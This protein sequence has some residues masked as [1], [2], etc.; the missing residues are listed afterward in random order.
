MSLLKN[1][2]A[3]E[4]LP[5]KYIIIAL[6]AAL[7]V[8]IA[9]QFTGVLKGG[10]MNTANKIN[11]STTM[12]TTCALDTED[13]VASDWSIT[14]NSTTNLINVASVKVTD[15]CDLDWVQVELKHNN[16]YLGSAYLTESSTKDVWTSN[17]NLDFTDSN[18]VTETYNIVADDRV[19]IWAKDKASTPNYA[20]A[21]TINCT[22]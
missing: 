19:V 3:V 6:V 11:E 16:D 12:Q 10:I 9:L 21:I 5:L 1:K 17:G 13:P 8:G 20:T 18:Q 22:S 4:G 15:D 2:K 14:C 7:V